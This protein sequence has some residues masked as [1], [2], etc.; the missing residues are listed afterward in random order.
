MK[1]TFGQSVAVTLFGESHGKAIGAVLDGMAPGIPVDE[2]FI[3]H[4]MDLR[5]SVSSLSTPRKEADKVII[6]SG[7]HN[8]VTTGTPITFMIE[9]TNTHSS[10]YE[11]LRTVARPGHAD[12][13]AY[14]KYHGFSDTRGGGHFSGR[15]TAG[16]VAAGAVAISALQAHGIYIGTHIAKC[17]GIAD[18]A[19]NKLEEDIQTLSSLSFAV[20]DESQAKKMQTA[21]S[22]AKAEG[23][24]VGGIL[25]TAVIG[26]PKGIGE[27]WFDTME[28]VLSHIL[29]SV[30][31]VKGVEFGD[32]FA[33]AD[34]KGSEANDAFF[35]NNGQVFTETNHAGGILGGITSGM[36]LIFRCAIKPT[37]SIFKTQHT[38]DFSKN[39]DCELSL[40][41]RHD[42]AIVHRARVVIDSVTAL[43]L[44]DM[45]ALRFGTDFLRKE[46]SL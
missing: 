36:P 41:G 3:A 7:V 45:L 13:T 27:P 43:A 30:P 17:A 33:L 19:F 23:D 8:G 29:F 6:L 9:N 34:K 12:Y 38:I 46:N 15:I 25:E 32:G 28:S 42:P 16:L 44:C 35:S 20:L 14:C 5:K 26:L 24:S 37:P 1:N 2:E 11:E 22:N 10:D 4:Q 18:R 21:I 39:T 40:K 31:A